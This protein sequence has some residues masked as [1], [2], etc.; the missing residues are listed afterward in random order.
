MAA[1]YKEIDIF[2]I[3]PGAFVYDA[4]NPTKYTEALS[5]TLSKNLFNAQEAGMVWSQGIHPEIIRLVKEGLQ[6]LKDYY[7]A[8]QAYSAAVNATRGL[9]RSGSRDLPDI[10]RPFL[11]MILRVG[12]F[13]TRAWAIVKYFNW[14]GI[15]IEAAFQIAVW[16]IERSI[17]QPT[18]ELD[19]TPL[20]D[21]IDEIL[22][23][24]D[25]ETFDKNA[26][27]DLIRRAVEDLVLK[28]SVTRL[29]DNCAFH[30]KAQLL[31]Y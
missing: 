2:G 24:I 6:A 16:L 3:D 17:T 19:I 12:G 22:G 31:E 25:G 5:H 28:D 14:W 13:L 7:E 23:N 1:D 4:E 26:V 11:P 8:M 9:S 29:G 18:T 15:A 10:I 20:I 30:Q 27:P 21:K